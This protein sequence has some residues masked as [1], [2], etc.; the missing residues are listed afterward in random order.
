[1]YTLPKQ[2]LLELLSHYDMT[3]MLLKCFDVCMMDSIRSIIQV[4]R[5]VRNH[6]EMQQKLQQTQAE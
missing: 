4:G 2:V 6:I 1:M 5:E 3:F